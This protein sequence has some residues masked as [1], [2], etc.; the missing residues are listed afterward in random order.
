[1]TRTDL[2]ASMESFL[3]FIERMILSAAVIAAGST[4][5]HTTTLIANRAVWLA[6]VYVV[7]G[8]GFIAAISSAILYFIDIRETLR[9]GRHGLLPQI[10]FWIVI[11]SA[12]VATVGL[13]AKFSD[14]QAKKEAASKTEATSTAT[15]KP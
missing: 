3:K 14:L 11:Y 9:R 7:I 8:V 5:V 13:T 6:S 10:A 4:L 15:A 1:M 12:A 2:Q